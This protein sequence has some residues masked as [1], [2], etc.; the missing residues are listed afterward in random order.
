MH[1]LYVHKNYPAQFGH[2]ARWLID[3]EGFRCTFISERE[4]GTN[5]P[6]RR[7]QYKPGGGATNTT[8][9]CSRT[10][11]NFTWHTHAIYETLK[12]HREVKPDLIVGH[13]GFGST[14]PI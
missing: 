3:H 9:F 1:I 5:G 4:P 7:L 8:H 10:I 14:E 11:E 2:I 13:S 12:A 6:I